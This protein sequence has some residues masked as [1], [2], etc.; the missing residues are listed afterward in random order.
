MTFDDGPD[1]GWTPRILDVLAEEGASATFFVLAPAAS[2][3]PE[4]IARAVD[5]GHE[6]AL[7]AE[8]HVRHTEMDHDAIAADAEAGLARL[9]ELGAEPA[10][11]RTPWGVQTQAT[12]N[13]A[14][15]LGLELVGWTHDSR[16]WSGEPAET[17]LGRC[18]AG[19]AGGS[20]VLMHDGLGPGATREGCGET[21]R[22]TRDLIVQAR[23]LG[24]EALSLERR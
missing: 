4:L 5:E 14:C 17:M 9:S 8:R 21:V 2:E 6:V 3:H 1:P 7:H 12:R 15:A 24:L 20:I 13:V 11:W 23:R 18:T 19:L 16:D 22:L 10:R